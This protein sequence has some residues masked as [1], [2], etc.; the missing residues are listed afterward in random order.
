MGCGHAHYGIGL[1]VALQVRGI[2]SMDGDL[3]FFMVY[4]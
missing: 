1:E 3:I 4:L 2:N